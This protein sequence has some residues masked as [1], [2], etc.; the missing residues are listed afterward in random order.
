MLGSGSASRELWLYTCDNDKKAKPHHMK[1]QRI[2]SKPNFCCV[3]R[4]GG[5]RWVKKVVG[6]ELEWMGGVK[7]RGVGRG[8]AVG[9]RVSLWV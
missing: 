8:G 5:W 4:Q 9:G 6:D 7:N 2:P 3:V 1:Q